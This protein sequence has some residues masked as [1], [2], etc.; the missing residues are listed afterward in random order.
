MLAYPG[1]TVEAIETT[2]TPA[3]LEDLMR[4][5][6]DDP[7]PFLLLHGLYE[8]ATGGKLRQKIQDE[9]DVNAAVAALAAAGVRFRQ[10]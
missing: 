10:E 5:W 6:S 8:V 2:L 1:Y 9:D 3:Q 4:C 7:P